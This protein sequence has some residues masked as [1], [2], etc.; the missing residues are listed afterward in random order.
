[1][2][3]FNWGIHYNIS[4]DPI[5]L[6]RHIIISTFLITVLAGFNELG[7]NKSSRF[8]KSAMT[9]KHFF[10]SKKLGFNEYS[11]IMFRAIR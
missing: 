7:F 10:T 9:S 5:V 1:M 6:S 4:N 8:Y 11:G 2:R 3:L